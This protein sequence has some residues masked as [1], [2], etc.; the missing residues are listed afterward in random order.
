MDREKIIKSIILNLETINFESPEL[1]IK[2]R[3]SAMDL[4]DAIAM[5]LHGVVGEVDIK[6]CPH[7]KDERYDLTT[8]GGPKKFQCLQCN[9]VIEE[10]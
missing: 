3:A 7:P 9:E 2:Q 6:N 5:D 1:A 4:I 10:E 8:I